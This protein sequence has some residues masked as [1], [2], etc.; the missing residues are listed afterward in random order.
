VI[1]RAKLR[2]WSR[3]LF[4]MKENLNALNGIKITT[5]ENNTSHAPFMGAPLGQKAP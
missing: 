2:I 1:F 3:P 5:G 4:Y